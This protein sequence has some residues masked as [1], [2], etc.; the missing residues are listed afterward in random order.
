M[1]SSHPNDADLAIGV[2]SI[3]HILKTAFKDV[4]QEEAQKVKEKEEKDLTIYSV[5]N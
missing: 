4:Y 5:K 2:G 1:S 3:S